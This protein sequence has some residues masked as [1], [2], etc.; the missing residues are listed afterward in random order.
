MRAVGR[1][2]AV[3]SAVEAVM[4]AETVIDKV[5]IARG[6]RRRGLRAGLVDGAIADE[7]RRRRGRRRRLA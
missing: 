6:A 5:R 1:Q 4:R 3:V 7:G 2:V